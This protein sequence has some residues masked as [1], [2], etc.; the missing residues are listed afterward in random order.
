MPKSE[1]FRVGD[2]RCFRFKVLNPCWKGSGLGAEGASVS[3]FLPKL[4]GF[5][6]CDGM[7]FRFNVLNPRWMGFRVWDG[8]CFW[9]PVLTGWV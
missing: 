7:R 3:R 2:G 9:V 6:V 5:R 4:E 1:G 8:R